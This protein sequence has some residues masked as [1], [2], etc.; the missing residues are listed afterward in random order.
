[1]TNTAAAWIPDR[2]THSVQ[3]GRPARRTR[4]GAGRG[5]ALPRA[6]RPPRGLAWPLLPALAWP[7]LPALAWP[8][9]PALAWPSL[10]AL[11]WPL[12]P[13]LAWP[14]LPALAWPSRGLAW[15]LPARPA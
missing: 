3:P 6:W 10:P 4:R 8:S 12:L 5:R 9:L 15:P 14:S 11:A 13:A 2:L 7:S 1:M